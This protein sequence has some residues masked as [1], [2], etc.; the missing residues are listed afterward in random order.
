MEGRHLRPTAG[1]RGRGRAARS[2]GLALLAALWPCFVPAQEPAEAA[3]ERA[4]RAARAPQPPE[5]DGKLED[6]VWQVAE[7][8]DAFVQIFPDEGS[9]PSEPTEVRVLYDDRALYVAVR[10]RDSRPDQIVRPM[11]RRDKPPVSDQV[12]LYIDTGRHLD[13]YVFGLTAGGIQ[14]DGVIYEDDRMAWDWDAVWDGRVTV[15]GQGWSAEFAI[16]LSVLRFPE[17]PV[18][19][20]GFAVRRELAR[21]RELSATVL[22][23]RNAR[24]LVSRLSH[25]TGLTDLRP[26]ADL[27]LVPYAAARVAI[28]PQYRSKPEIPEP[29][30][31][32]LI[33]DA[34]LDLKWVPSRSLSLVATLNPDFG[35]VEAD[36]IIQN[37]TTYEVKYPEK[38]SFFNEGLQLFQPVGSGEDDLP[39]PQQLFYSRRMGLETPIF[40]AAKLTSRLGERFQLSVLDA[41]VAGGGMPAGSSEAQPA[42]QMHWVPEQ[43]FHLAQ[44]SAY[45]AVKPVTENFLAGTLRWRAAP[46]ATFGATATSAIPFGQ[47]CA[48]PN[49]NDPLPASCQVA[50]GHAAALD[51][52]VRS[53]D[54]EWVFY[55]QAAGSIIEGG[56]PERT[57]PDGVELHPGDQGF[58]GY[59]ALRRIGGEPWRFD[60]LYE[61]QSPRLDLN[62]SGYLKTQNHQAVT[63]WLQYV[64]PSLTGTFLAWDVGLFAEALYTTDQRG[65]PRGRAVGLRLHARHESYTDFG[66]NGVLRDPV[67]D[68]RE[69]Q[70]SGLAYRRPPYFILT[71]YVSTNYS[72]PFALDLTAAGGWYFASGLVPKQP[73]ASADAAAQWRPHPRLETKL[74]LHLERSHYPAR[75]IASDPNPGPYGHLFADLDSPVVSAIV[76]QLVVLTPRLTFQLYAQLFLDTGRYNPLYCGASSDGK[77]RTSG[78]VPYKD[79]ASDCPAVPTL[80]FQD[81]RLNL[82]AVL[83]W[84]YRL[85]SVLYAVYTRSQQNPAW[86]DLGATPPTSLGPYW[87][88]PTI[89]TFMLKLSYWWNP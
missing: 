2:A 4:I 17:A 14:Q 82:N 57:Q 50:G 64:R 58:G 41:L 70:Q 22:I 62:A 46:E 65:L 63:A 72:R 61:Y 77:V 89:D 38:R 6:P 19:T 32:N 59:A 26:R 87:G 75:W 73:F 12:Y 83:R 76:R 21:R 86:G 88:G 29:R 85:G 79:H 51:W 25:L 44:G 39:V 48:Q 37:L 66:C 15:D 74:T 16:P 80:A 13:G 3:P 31:A 60:L 43:P 81:T 5:V 33:L 27:E 34:G 30:L 54:S 55:G 45:P 78:L 52:N 24:G 28:Q 23:P 36:E 35:Q 71:C 47:D 84:E 11:G 53:R 7:P 9:A 42:R 1:R 20:W 67:W 40:G 56:K 10:C 49:P 18:Q 69:I 8:F 68:V